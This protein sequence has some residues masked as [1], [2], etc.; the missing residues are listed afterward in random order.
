MKKI[1]FIFNPT[2]GRARIKTK[3]YE[4]VDFYSSRDYMVTVYATQKPWDGYELLMSF[5]DEY[6]LIVCSGGDGTLNEIISGVLDSGRE[7]LL[8]YM[9]SGST[10]DFGRSVGI[11]SEIEDAL[12][13]TVEG[14]PYGVD[15]GRFNNRYFVYVAAFGAFT[16]IPYT[17]PQKM[18]NSFG[19]LAYLLEGIKA[20]SELK[21]YKMVLHYDHGMIEGEFVV[22]LITNSF[23]VAGFKNPI[24]SLTE[25]NDGVFEVL[26]IRMPR[27][28]LELQE[29]VTSLLSENVNSEF[30]ECLQSSNIQIESE[31]M[32]WTF[33]GEYGGLYESV[34]IGNLNQAVKIMISQQVM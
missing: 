8:G 11:P 7:T 26:L 20:I 32:A 30:I 23:S 33:D 18:K 27:N 3:L 4:I 28:I 6:D 29:I 19:Y 5:Q 31:P 13:V 12:A 15:V 34:Q 24:H 17:T 21:P 22:G 9:P 16:N 14:E 1:L 10:N 2:A 25:L